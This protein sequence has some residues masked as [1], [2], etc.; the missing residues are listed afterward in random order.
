M[1]HHYLWHQRGWVTWWFPWGIEVNST[2]SPPFSSF[3]SL[4]FSKRSQLVMTF[5]CLVLGWV[6]SEDDGG[7]DG[8]E[9][10]E[11]DNS[12]DVM[13]MMIVLLNRKMLMMMMMWILYLN[14][15]TIINHLKYINIQ[16]QHLMN[17]LNLWFQRWEE[18]RSLMKTP[19][20]LAMFYFIFVTF[21]CFCC[22]DTDDDNIFVALQMQLE[23]LK[24]QLLNIVL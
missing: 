16:H 10:D 17:I 7:C 1:W 14:F 3:P 20:L 8:E 21:S 23:R 4:L 13:M 11:N 19:M 12:G 2:S 5:V 24:Y 22:L 9:D 6:C 15:Q 18:S